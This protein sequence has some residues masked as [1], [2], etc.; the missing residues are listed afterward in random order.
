MEYRIRGY[1]ML[2]VS[3]VHH[4]VCCHQYRSGA[5]VRGNRSGRPVAYS[6]GSTEGMI[7]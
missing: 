4:Q 5:V 2:G 1:P 3:T 7:L 6:V